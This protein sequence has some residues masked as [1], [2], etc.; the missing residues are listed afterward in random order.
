MSS[1]VGEQ[2]EKLEKLQSDGWRGKWLEVLETCKQES[3]LRTA[4]ITMTGD[5]LVQEEKCLTQNNLVVTVDGDNEESS[6]MNV[7]LGAENDRKN[8][9]LHIAAS[10]GK[11]AI[12]KKLGRANPSLIAR[13]N[14]AGETPLF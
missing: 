3:A 13:R 10:M 7:I 5:F 4:K 1:L 11:V 9:P 6:N 14:I 12:C 2:Q 8:T